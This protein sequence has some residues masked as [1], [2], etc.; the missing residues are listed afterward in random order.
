MEG[1]DE[2]HPRFAPAETCVF[3]VKLDFQTDSANTHQLEP[4]PPQQSSFQIRRLGL[5]SVASG[6]LEPQRPDL[7]YLVFGSI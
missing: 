6:P 5:V 1:P 7:A 4:R 3:N 2:P